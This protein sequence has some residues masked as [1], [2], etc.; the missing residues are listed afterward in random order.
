MSNIF[1]PMAGKKYPLGSAHCSLKSEPFWQSDLRDL[2]C[3][4]KQGSYNLGQ[5]IPLEFDLVDN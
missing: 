4:Q 1:A 5:K 2:G 3:R